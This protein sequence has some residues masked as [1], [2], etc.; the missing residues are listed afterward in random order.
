MKFL[1]ARDR[2]IQSDVSDID[3]ILEEEEMLYAISES[4]INYRK[5]NNLSQ[6]ELAKK[7]NVNQTMISKLESGTYNPTFIKIQQM[8]RELTNSPEMFI[9][10]LENIK[11]AIRR[12][13]KKSYVIDNKPKEYVY[14]EKSNV[15]EFNKYKSVSLTIKNGEEVYGEYQSKI[16]AIG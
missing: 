10:I 9:E 13:T 2:K 8:C 1:N 7:L 6:T 3:E 11:R 5:S 16:P 4:I 15:I 12:V 14:S